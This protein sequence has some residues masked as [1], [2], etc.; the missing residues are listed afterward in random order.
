MP[1]AFIA[2]TTLV[3]WLSALFTFKSMLENRWTTSPGTAAAASVLVIAFIVFIACLTM[4]LAC[5]P[6]RCERP[7]A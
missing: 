6:R 1:V 3:G 5:R 2:V 7:G 4:S